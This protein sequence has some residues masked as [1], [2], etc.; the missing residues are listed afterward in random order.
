MQSLA[1]RNL[2]WRRTH[3][4]YSGMSIFH[5]MASH[6]K[7]DAWKPKFTS[8]QVSPCGRY[9]GRFR[10]RLGGLGIRRRSVMA[11]TQHALRIR[12]TYQLSCP[13]FFAAL[14]P[15]TRLCARSAVYLPLP[16]LLTLRKWRGKA[17]PSLQCTTW[18]S[19]TAWRTHYFLH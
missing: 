17:F 2:T 16:I 4:A 12:F 7:R 8:R 9:D 3:G 14:V 1:E 6:V 18:T 15:A 5:P 19:M 10:D 11:A 13:R